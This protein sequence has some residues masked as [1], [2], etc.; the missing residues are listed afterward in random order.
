[1]EATRPGKERPLPEQVRKSKRF[2]RT[3]ENATEFK[4]AVRAGMLV[5][6][7]LRKLVKDLRLADTSISG[8]L[9]GLLLRVVRSDQVNDRGKRLVS[10]GEVDLLEDFIFQENKPFSSVFQAGPMSTMDTATGQVSVSVR[11]FNPQEWIAAPDDATHYKLVL[12]SPAIHFEKERREQELTESNYLLLSEPMAGPLCL[13]HIQAA[14]PGYC[15]LSALGVVFYKQTADG[16]FTR[17]EGGV[18]KILQ[19]A[20]A[21]GETPFRKQGP[22]QVTATLVQEEVKAPA[23]VAVATKKVV[24]ECVMPHTAIH[25]GDGTG[26]VACTGRNQEGSHIGHVLRRSEIAQGISRLAKALRSS[27]LK[28]GGYWRYQSGPGSTKPLRRCFEAHRVQ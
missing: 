19:V 28:N 13:E 25:Q 15:L 26:D 3:R 14:Q 21:A 27:S 7:S 10:K 18:M 23:C 20:M 2:V 24:S 22:T 11:A 16:Q 9:H 6:Y 8:K 17:V 12:N 4:R 5:R 1:M